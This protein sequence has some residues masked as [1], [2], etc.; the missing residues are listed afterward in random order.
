MQNEMLRKPR[1][2]VQSHNVQSGSVHLELRRCNLGSEPGTPVMLV[3]GFLKTNDFFLQQDGEGGLAQFLALQGY[4]VFLAE[5]RGRGKSW[6]GIRKGADWGAHEAI[7]NDIPAHL[8]MIERLRPG[9]PQIWLGQDFSSVLLAAVYARGGLSTPVRGMIH[10]GAGRFRQAQGSD[11]IFR[12]WAAATGL[13]RAVRGYVARPFGDY[14]C[15]ETGLS[16]DCWRRWQNEEAWLDPVDDFDYR[17]ALQTA[18][19]PPSLYLANGGLSLWGSLKDCR[20][21]VEE[22]GQHDA[23][24][25]TIGRRGG[26]LRNYS[27][28]GL[29]QHPEAGEDHFLQIHAWLEERDHSLQLGAAS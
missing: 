17:A 8:K 23:R 19:L 21:W 22:M 11:T 2:Q 7:C 18:P 14:N 25:I 20:R 10:A 12:L 3:P 29:V 6:P 15:R 5:L 4:D 9:V 13:S 26:N 1:L 27:H 24:I 28:R 16:L